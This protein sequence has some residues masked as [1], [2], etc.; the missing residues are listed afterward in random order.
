MHEQLLEALALLFVTINPIS[1]AVYFAGASGG[2]DAAMR[3]RVAV[4]ATLVAMGILLVFAIGGDDLLQAVGIRLFSLKISG[5]ILLF[6]FGLRMVMSPSASN[7]AARETGLAALEDQAV[8]PL[9]MP[10]TAGPASI[11]TTV[12]LIDRAGGNYAMQGAIMGMVVLVLLAGLLLMLASG[13]V[14]RLL[15]R[16]GAEILYRIMGLL[17]ASLAVEMVIDGLVLAHIINV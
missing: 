11:L 15:G 14:S 3:F 8:F 7:A 12:I 4:K 2:S 9:A 6:L 16:Q 1:T 13:R 10:I 5:G 17:L